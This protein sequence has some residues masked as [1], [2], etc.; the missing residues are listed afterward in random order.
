MDLEGSLNDRSDSAKAVCANSMVYVHTCF[1][2][3]SLEF[4]Y[5]LSKGYLGDWPPVK[6][7]GAECLMSF[8]GTHVMCCHK[9]LL[10]IK[11]IL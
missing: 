6:P 4:G 3:E 7:P 2:S 10:G 11:C 9:S 8:P 1:S 5:A